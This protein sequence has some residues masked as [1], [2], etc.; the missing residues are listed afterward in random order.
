MAP[1]WYRVDVLGK[2]ERPIV[3]HVEWLAN[4]ETRTT[5][6]RVTREDGVGHFV[7]TRLEVP[8]RHLWIIQSRGDEKPDTA[9]IY[10]LVERHGDLL[11]I[12]F[13]IDCD[14]SAEIVR[15]A[16]GTVSGGSRPE[17]IDMTP[18]ETRRHRRKGA[19]D[20]HVEPTTVMTP[21][22]GPVQNQHCTFADRSSLERALV[23]YATA[24][25]HLDG[26]LLLRKLSD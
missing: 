13:P 5:P 22:T 24:H 16:G 4:G 10:G 19:P 11:D 20:P 6:R 18:T 7:A 12:A 3:Q 1:G 14:S 2:N 23:A 9:A 17:A 26:G 25:P 21:T 8:G 15:A